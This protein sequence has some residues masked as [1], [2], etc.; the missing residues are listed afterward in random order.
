MRLENILSVL[1]GK[2]S[3]RQIV[4]LGVLTWNSGF[5]GLSLHQL[6]SRLAGQ[7]LD[8]LWLIAKEMKTQRLQRLR[9]IRINFRISHRTNIISEDIL[10]LRLWEKHWRRMGILGERFVE[11]L[12]YPGEGGRRRCYWNRCPDSG[13]FCERPGGS[14]QVYLAEIVD[15][16]SQ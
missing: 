11:C 10:F 2:K 8:S 1:P 3:A 14:H 12:W 15:A 6:L 4:N 9:E 5:N 16:V 13:R 7:S